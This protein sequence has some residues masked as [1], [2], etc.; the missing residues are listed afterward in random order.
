MTSE[1]GRIPVYVPETLYRRIEAIV[2]K[3]D[4]VNSVDD[5]VIRVLREFIQAHEEDLSEPFS[6][7]EKKEILERLKRLGYL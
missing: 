7:E 3:L 6:E 4:N 1:D 5:Y 2:R